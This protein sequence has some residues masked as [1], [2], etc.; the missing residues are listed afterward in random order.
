MTIGGLADVYPAPPFITANII[1]FGWRAPRLA[2][3]I[4]VAT[5]KKAVAIEPDTRVVPI[6]GVYGVQVPL[7]GITTTTTGLHE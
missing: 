5:L 6:A 7:L 3:T 2:S 1:L 4:G